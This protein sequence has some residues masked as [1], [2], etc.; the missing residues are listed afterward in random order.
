MDLET[1]T[2][3]QCPDLVFRA[4]HKVKLRLN[5]GLVYFIRSCAVNCTKYLILSSYIVKKVG[6]TIVYK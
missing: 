2:V 5:W 4:K 3:P 6:H 1:L